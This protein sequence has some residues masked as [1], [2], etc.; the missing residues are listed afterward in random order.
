MVGCTANVRLNIMKSF[1][2]CFW[3]LQ[4]AV[5]CVGEV[6]I[7]LKDAPLPDSPIVTLPVSF[8]LPPILQ[9]TQPKYVSLDHS[10]QRVRRVH[11][12]DEW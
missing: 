3:G 10:L 2:A 5:R 9:L 8:L 7:N 11:T 1:P 4:K 12:E 6:T